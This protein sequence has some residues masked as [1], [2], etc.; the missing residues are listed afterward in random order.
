[1]PTNN[2]FNP[3]GNCPHKESRHREERK[4]VILNDCGTHHFL[5]LTQLQIDLLDYLNSEG[6]TD[7]E[8]EKTED[9]RWVEV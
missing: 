1:M 9:T 6:I 7:L 8:W 4:T 3:C 2:T 5:K